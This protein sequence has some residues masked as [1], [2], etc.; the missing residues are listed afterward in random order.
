MKKILLICLF[1]LSVSFQAMAFN[2]DPSRYEFIGM[3]SDGCAIFYEIPSAKAD[4]QKAIILMLQVDPKNRIMRYYRDVVI[5]PEAMTIKSTYCELK[6]YSNLNL[7][8]SFALPNE[9]VGY[10]KG[11]L[12]DKIYQDLL[13]KGIVHKPAP[14][15]AP[16]PQQVQQY[17]APQPEPSTYSSATWQEGFAGGEEVIVN[18]DI[19]DDDSVIADF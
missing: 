16:T 12:T 6:D 18:L 11:S 14:V 13:N 17:V 1:L 9:T 8:D 4:G 7:L 2:P 5:D 3:K 19:D 15:V 10:T